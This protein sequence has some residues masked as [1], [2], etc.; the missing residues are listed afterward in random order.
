MNKFLLFYTFLICKLKKDTNSLLQKIDN[1]LQLVVLSKQHV[2]NE[3]MCNG[4]IV[5][6]IVAIN[7]FELLW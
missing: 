7:N 4:R 6:I 1:L 3:I 5:Q 2:N